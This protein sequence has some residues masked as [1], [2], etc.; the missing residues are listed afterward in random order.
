VEVVV[1]AAEVSSV[2]LP[3]DLVLTIIS[4]LRRWRRIWRRRGRILR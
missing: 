1:A 2:Y 3:V 4:R